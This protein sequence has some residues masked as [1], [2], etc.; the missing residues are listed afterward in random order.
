MKADEIVNDSLCLAEK[1]S[2][3]LPIFSLKFLRVGFQFGWF[4]ITHTNN[5]NNDIVIVITIVMPMT[6]VI[7]DGVLC[8]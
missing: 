8:S 3:S 1:I 2:A 5:N 6:V 7:S 4:I